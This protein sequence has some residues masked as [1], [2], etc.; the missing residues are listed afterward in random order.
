V[1]RSLNDQAAMLRTPR[2]W[3][4][5]RADGRYRV[6]QHPSPA[7]LERARR[8]DE[9]AQQARREAIQPLQRLAG[10]LKKDP[11]LE[12]DPAKKSTWYLATAIYYHWIGELE[13]S[14]GT[15]GAAL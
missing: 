3:E 13:K 5:D 9:Q 8:L 6:T 12:T 7:D 15:A 11:T 10:T 14:A 1:A 4:E 2:V